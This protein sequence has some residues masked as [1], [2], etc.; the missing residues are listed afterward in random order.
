MPAAAATRLMI[1][2][3]EPPV[4]ACAP[5]VWYLVTRRKIGPSVISAAASQASIAATGHRADPSKEGMPTSRPWPSWSSLVRV[6]STT[7][8]SAVSTDLVSV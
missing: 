7:Y 1:F 5:T 3:T 2:A 8:P 6:S 4:S